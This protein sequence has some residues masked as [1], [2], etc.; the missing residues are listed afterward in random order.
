M[1][2]YCKRNLINLCNM[3]DICNVNQSCIPNN[4]TYKEV[5]VIGELIYFM[6]SIQILYIVCFNKFLHFSFNCEPV[7]VEKEF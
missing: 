3:K 5:V 4:A 1:K 6:S 7:C 2:K